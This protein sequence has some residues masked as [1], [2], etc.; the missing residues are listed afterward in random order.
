ME[1]YVLK[2]KFLPQEELQK[3]YSYINEIKAS[4]DKFALEHGF[5]RGAFIMT[6]GC[7]QNEADSEKIAGIAS[8]MGYDESFHYRM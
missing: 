4:N 7:Q 3:Q 8:A 2:T 5:R 1:K 6:F